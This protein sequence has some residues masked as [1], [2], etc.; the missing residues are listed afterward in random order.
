MESAP[1][2]K[3]KPADDA[4]F[5]RMAVLTAFFHREAVRSRHLPKLLYKALT[6]HR[7]LDNQHIPYGVLHV[8]IVF[9]ASD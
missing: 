8:D 3:L 9:Q 1:S 4:F 2:L 5:C 6:A 7:V